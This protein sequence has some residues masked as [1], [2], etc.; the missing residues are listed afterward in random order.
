L[1]EAEHG[2][3]CPLLRSGL[4]VVFVGFNPSPEAWR[5]GHY[6]AHPRNRFWE[7]LHASGL[8]ARRLTAWEDRELLN[9]GMGLTDVVG[10]PS[11]CASELAPEELEA[12]GTAVR[13]RLARFR[14]SV[15]AYTGKGVYRAV[16]GRPPAG[17][18]LQAGQAVP[19]VADFVLPSPSGRSGIPWAEKVAWYGQLARLLDSGEVA[20]LVGEPGS[21]AE[22]ALARQMGQLVEG[23][24]DHPR[25]GAGGTPC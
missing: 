4:R 11:A 20:R 18:G 14:P 19:G 16:A 3:W 1:A 5:V 23:P 24:Q 8:V 21:A 9:F 25:S 6:Y 2:R 7:L 22:A 10:R 17:Y 12:G 15:A 13:R